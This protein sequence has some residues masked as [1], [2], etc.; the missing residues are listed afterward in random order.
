MT[1]LSPLPSLTVEEVPMDQ[2]R[3]DRAKPR[4]IIDARL[5]STETPVGRHRRSNDS[6]KAAPPVCGRTDEFPG[7]L[8]CGL[9]S[10]LLVN[11]R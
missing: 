9:S 11:S 8:S 4:Q 1:P 2:L 10:R 7:S 5:D 6:E 3:P